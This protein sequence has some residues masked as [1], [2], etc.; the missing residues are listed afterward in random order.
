MKTIN[1]D[2]KE[3]SYKIAIAKG[4]KPLIGILKKLNPGKDA[5]I[6][7]NPLILKLHGQKLAAALKSA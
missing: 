5:F 2:L 4:Y 6:I 7:T 3:R 1:I